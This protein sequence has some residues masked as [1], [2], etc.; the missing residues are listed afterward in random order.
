MTG[1]GEYSDQRHLLRSNSRKDEDD[2]DDNDYDDDLESQMSNNHNNAFTDLFKHLDRGFSARRISFKRLDRDRDRSSPSSIDHHHNHHAYVM[3][4]ADALGDSA[5]PEWALLLISCLLGV[6]SGLFVAAF[7]KGVGFSFTF[8]R[9]YFFCIFTF[10]ILR[11]LNS[12][13]N[14]FNLLSEGLNSLLFKFAFLF[15]HHP[16]NTYSFF[17]KIL[18]CPLLR[19]LF[20][21]TKLLINK[22]LNFFNIN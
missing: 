19:F 6:A 10:M 20:Y 5:P 8:Q 9:C 11:S 1:A 12:S 3:D 15:Y 22:N 13:I 16:T 14:G 7:N 21:I 4:A 2:D 17:C 18:L